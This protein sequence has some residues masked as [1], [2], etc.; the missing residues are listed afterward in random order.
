MEQVM[1]EKYGEEEGMEI[2]TAFSEAIH[3]TESFVV[4]YRRDLSSGGGM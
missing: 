1:L 3:H 2:F 4:R